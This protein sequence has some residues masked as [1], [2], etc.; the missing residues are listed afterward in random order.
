MSIVI[1]VIAEAKETRVAELKKATEVLKEDHRERLALL[2]EESKTQLPLTHASLRQ[3]FISSCQIS[4]IK[5]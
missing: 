3:N 1:I 4:P 5:G 2:Q